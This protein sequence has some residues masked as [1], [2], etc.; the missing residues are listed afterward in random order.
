MG[1]EDLTVVERLCYTHSSWAY[2]PAQYLYCFDKRPARRAGFHNNLQR[3]SSS[4]TWCITRKGVFGITWS[5]T[6]ESF[7]HY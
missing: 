5:A 4:A 3:A 6:E 1:A 7:A 2:L